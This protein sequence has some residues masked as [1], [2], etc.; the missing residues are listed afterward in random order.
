VPPYSWGPA[1]ISTVAPL[2]PVTQCLA[3]PLIGLPTHRLLGDFACLALGAAFL[4]LATLLIGSP[5]LLLQ[6][7]PR[8]AVWLPYAVFV[9]VALS[10]VGNA[11]LRSLSVRALL[12]GG[13]TQAQASV[14]AACLDMLGLY[15]GFICGPLV[16]GQ[17]IEHYGVAALGGVFAALQ[18][19]SSGFL[20]AT[21]APMLLRG[22]KEEEAKAS[23]QATGERDQSE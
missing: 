9:P 19:L 3:F 17:V 7:L 18:L 11:P 23:E 21:S 20:L 16:S 13:M 4:L 22:H 5:P 6:F 10:A 8:D 12:R 2:L 14:P 1:H 15:L